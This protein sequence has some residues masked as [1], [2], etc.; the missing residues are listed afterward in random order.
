VP[1]TNRAAGTADAALVPGPASP[2]PK[3]SSAYV[4]CGQSI[5]P[6]RLWDETTEGEVLDAIG[7]AKACAAE[8]GRH[9]LLEFVAPWCE[10]CQEMARLDETS[11]V[12]ATLKE[13]FERVRVNVGKWDRHEGLRQRFDV[14]V[15]ATYV[16]IEPKTSA[17][18]AKT[19]LEPITKKGQRLTAFDWQRWL[20]QH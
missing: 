17:V 13:R 10:D 8:N 7:S 11:E 19:T 3:T 1:P 4:G 12:A 15:L 2:P 20:S 18:L 9:L 16:V 6:D 5:P 14:H